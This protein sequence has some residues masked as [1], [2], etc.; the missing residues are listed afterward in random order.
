MYIYNG[1]EDNPYY[2]REL[3]ESDDW[4]FLSQKIKTLRSMLF[5]QNHSW[6]VYRQWCV[7]FNRV[8]CKE[9]KGSHFRESP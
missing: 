8:G 3:R 4:F 2:D 7:G 9:Y 1:R 6:S 5:W